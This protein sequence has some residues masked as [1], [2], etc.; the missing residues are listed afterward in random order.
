M[1]DVETPQKPSEKDAK[2]CQR[3]SMDRR[4][5][6]AVLNN[7]TRLDNDDDGGIIWKL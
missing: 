6:A 5:V 3:F 4:T 2:G 1:T 7:L